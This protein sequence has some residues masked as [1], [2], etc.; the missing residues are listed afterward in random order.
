MEDSLMQ[1]EEGLEYRFLYND[2]FDS[3]HLLLSLID[4]EHKLSNVQP[5]YQLM[6][7][8]GTSLKR[9]LKSRKDSDYIIQAIR[10]R[11]N[12]DVNRLELAVFLK[13]YA[14]GLH[15]SFYVDRMERL[16]LQEFGEHELSHR[17]QLY[18][19]AKSGKVM[20]LQSAVFRT[21]KMETKELQN[22]RQL[23]NMYC[24]RV[25]RGK[26]YGLNDVLDT[27]IVLD[28][29]HLTHLKVEE[30]KLTMKELTFLYSKICHY[31]YN[32]I[33]KVYKYAYWNGINDA[34]LER[35]AK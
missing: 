2:D 29:E 14:N 23:S 31:L 30:E 19:T 12:D 5:R 13:G 3:M 18:H 1:I 21:I 22:A 17:H 25:L 20:G 16:A 9:A 6:K 15:A 32:N 28:F 26:I 4:H 34:V 11:I 8:L 27:Q 10:K 33:A 24:K 35:Y 7:R